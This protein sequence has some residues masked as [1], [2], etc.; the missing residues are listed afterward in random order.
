MSTSARASESEKDIP[1]H[2]PT[3]SKPPS[4]HS[5]DGEFKPGWR[6]ILAFLSLTTITLM[7]ALDATSLSVALPTIARKLGGSAIQAFWSGTSFLLA[8]TVFQPVL[9]SFSS[10]FGRKPILFISLAFFGVGAIV[11]AVAKNFT[12][13]L[14]GRTIQ[15]IGGGG[16]I[17][18][19][20]VIVTDMVPL[21]VRGAWFS[22]ISSAWAIG[23]LPNVFPMRHLLM[24]YRNRQRPTAGWRLCPER[25][26]GMDLLDQ[27]AIH[28]TRLSSHHSVLASQLPNQRLCRQAA[29]GGL[30]WR[31][32][33]HCVSLRILD[34]AYMGRRHVSMEPLANSGPLDPLRIWL[35]RFRCIRRVAH[36]KGSS[37]LD[38]LGSH[39]ES[40][41]SSNL[42]WYRHP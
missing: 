22:F 2:S 30:D 17:T 6:F 23:K 10:I 32:S 16:V 9:G 24:D 42:L 8:S 18:L 31:N 37:T 33:L 38:S 13:I 11:A 29:A 21:R 28:R 15:G 4:E 5:P 25:V 20:E 7:V 36:P 34:P 39:E 12:V 26:V 14:V 41:S 35:G 27:L 3:S 1:I 19:T 40:N